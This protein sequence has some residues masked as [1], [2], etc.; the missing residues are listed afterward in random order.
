MFIIILSG[1]KKV[2]NFIFFLF[3]SKF[4]TKVAKPFSKCY[5]ITEQVNMI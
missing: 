4:S 2:Q 3:F 5:D 1:R